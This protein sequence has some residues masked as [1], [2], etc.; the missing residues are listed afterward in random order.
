MKRNLT[1]GGFT[2]IEILVV[3][4]I[5]SILVTV[6]EFRFIATQKQA[7]LATAYSQVKTVQ[8]AFD[9]Y[10]TMSPPSATNNYTPVSGTARYGYLLAQSTAVGNSFYIPNVITPYIL[11][12]QT[13]NGAVSPFSQSGTNP[14]TTAS[15]LAYDPSGYIN[16]TFANNQFYVA[17]VLP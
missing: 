15:I 5:I 7:H 12:V 17:L 6:G 9:Y 2:L 14:I 1:K 8:D 16:I 3:L 11:S 4:A 10:L 13:E